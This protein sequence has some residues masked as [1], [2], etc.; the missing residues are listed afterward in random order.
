M[1]VA[2][3]VVEYGEA[4][5]VSS[6]AGGARACALGLWGPVAK[7]S[8]DTSMYWWPGMEACWPSCW[9][10]DWTSLMMGDPYGMLLE[11]DVVQAYAT[12]YCSLDGR[13]QAGHSCWAYWQGSPYAGY[14]HAT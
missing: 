13:V 2:G 8:W 12:G 5:G 10:T 7:L 14:G 4:G 9:T 11:Y 1:E 3:R 6:P